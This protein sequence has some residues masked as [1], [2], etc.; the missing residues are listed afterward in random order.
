VK[1]ES[2][3]I[4]AFNSMVANQDGTVKCQREPF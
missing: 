1:S 3:M 2:E 4:G